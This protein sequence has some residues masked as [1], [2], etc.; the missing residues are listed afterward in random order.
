M[1]M[2][3]L[4]TGAH[5]QLASELAARAP[6]GWSVEAFA[7]VDL[8]IRDTAAIDA[9]VAR[10]APDLILNAA[11]YVAVDKAEGDSDTAYAVNRDGAANLARAATRVGARMAHV[12]TDF[13]FDGEK[14]RPYLPGDATNPLGVYGAS[15]LAGET[16][17]A[18]A[19][20]DALI[21][22]TAWVYSRTGGNFMKTML[23]LM[24]ERGEVRVVADQIG[25]PTVASG[26]ADTLWA[27]ALAGAVGVYHHT[28]AGVAS[29]YDFAEAIAEEG[30]AAGLLPTPPRVIPIPT[31]D[32]PT[33]ARR[34]AFS[35]LDKT[36][37][38]ALLGRRP[39]HWRS[40]LRG[41]LRQLGA[42]T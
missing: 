23:R 4:V 15:K 41:E 3:A 30:C 29:W 2:K 1:T 35:V 28:D 21:L 37:T 25:T 39:A 27:L 26:L 5:G 40:A 13:V 14:T 22:R 11:A 10:S 7:R 16:A 20:P 6:E 31:E 32:F 8:D 12:S 24:A 33:P 18:A 9:V 38:W 17:V 36:S 34:P 19:A 42:S